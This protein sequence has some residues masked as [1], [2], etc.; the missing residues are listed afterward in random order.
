M[1]LGV[2]ISLCVGPNRAEAINS[3]SYM[4]FSLKDLSWNKIDTC[5]L[6][7]VSLT[8]VT[9]VSQMNIYH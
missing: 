1:K 2:S 7:I 3:N 9:K 8:S 4:F 6:W 5:N